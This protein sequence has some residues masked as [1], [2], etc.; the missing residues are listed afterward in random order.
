[1]QKRWIAAA[2]L[3]LIASFSAHPQSPSGSPPGSAATPSGEQIIAR[4]V[5]AIGGRAAWESL[6]S[7]TS[8]GT[9]EFTSIPLSGTVMIHEK[10]P[11]RVL[12]VVIVEGAVFRQGFD[13]RVAWSDDPQDGVKT[14]SGEELSE[15]ARDADFYRPININKMYSKIAVTGQEE[16]EGRTAYL[17]EAT[18]T[19]GT[20]EKVDF[21]AQSG[22]IV[23]A[24]AQRHVGQNVTTF[25][26]DLQDYREV[27]GVK[28]PFTVV[29]TGGGAPF[30]IHFGEFHH[31]VDLEDSEFAKPDVQ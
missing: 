8:L 13:G 19:D 7:R 28:L 6:R 14:K 20:V 22:L 3:V 24:I 17:V 15:A 26:Q 9:I 23:R 27:D 31:N 21:D 30:T 11:N 16:I 18:S 10:A 4:Y 5:E 2:G 25:Q 1:M 29:Q 12:Q